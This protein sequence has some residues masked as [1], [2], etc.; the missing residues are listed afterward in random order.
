MSP[1]RVA[2]EPEGGWAS[3]AQ[4]RVAEEE[5]CWAIVRSC[6]PCPHQTRA[7]DRP[8]V[9]KAPTENSMWSRGWGW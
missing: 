6:P 8:P 4:R 9:R 5:E 7:L 3:Q 2:G 1:S